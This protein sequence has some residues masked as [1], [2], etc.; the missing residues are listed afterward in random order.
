[1][2]LLRSCLLLPLAASG[3]HA[4]EYAP[5]PANST[6]G[7]RGEYDGEPFEGRFARYD[8]RITYDASVPA[9]TAIE[10]TI[11][12]ASADTGLAERDETLRGSEFF[13][14]ERWP[15][16]RFRTTACRGAAPRIECDAELT[17]RDRT[18]RLPF[19]FA[20]TPLAD[21]RAK[22]EAKTVLERLAFDVGTGEWA[23]PETLADDV[24]VTVALEL[25]PR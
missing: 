12:L 4:A 21:G 10:A 5:D 16:A 8:A 24:E 17:I 1:M 19:A 11:E 14:T 3:A 23:D 20:W 6:L 2:T 7:F 9:R 13:A 25:V 22:L 18:Q 15:S